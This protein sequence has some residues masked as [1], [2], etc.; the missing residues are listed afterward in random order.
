MECNGNKQDS[1]SALVVLL[2]QTGADRHQHNN[3]LILTVITFRKELCEG[4]V[5]VGSDLM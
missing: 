5:K 4:R 3:D 1:L 2:F